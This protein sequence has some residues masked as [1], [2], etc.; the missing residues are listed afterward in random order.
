MLTIRPIHLKAANA[1][2]AAHH[3][4]NIPT[5]GGKF[6]VSCYE[7]ERL[8]G[9]AVCG[10]PVS[11]CLDDGFTLEIYRNCTDGTRNACSKLYGA[12]ARVAKAMGY[13]SVITYTLVSEFGTSLRASGFTCEGLAGGTVW[14]GSRRRNYYISPPE[15]K[16]RWR[17]VIE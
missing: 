4:H 1:Y 15:H 17:K 8:C 9:V 13:H 14:T 10:R 7:S 6:A 2:V 12:C 5:V 3:R 16:L 11:R